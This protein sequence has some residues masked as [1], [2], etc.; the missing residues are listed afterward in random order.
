MP[1]GSTPLKERLL[2]GT[3]PFHSHEKRQKVD[4]DASSSVPRCASEFGG[5][6]RVPP[7]ELTVNR[8]IY[9]VWCPS[10]TSFFPFSRV[11]LKTLLWDVSVSFQPGELVALMGASGAGKT[12]LL[13]VV[14]GEAGGMVSSREG[15]AVS[16]NLPPPCLSAVSANS[17]PLYRISEKE[18][19]RGGGGG[20]SAARFLGERSRLGSTRE[21]MKRAS[22][23]VPQDDTL[24]S[25]LTARQTLLYAAELSMP[26]ASKSERATRVSDVLSLLNLTAAAETKVGKS[27]EPNMRGLSGGERKRL[28]IGIELL[29][30]PSVLILDE[31][32]TGLDSRN[33]EDVLACLRMLA[34]EGR[35]VICSIHQPS[36][37]MMSRFDRV[38]LLDRGEVAY[39][40]KVSLLEKYF[41][42]LGVFV[43]ERENPIERYVRAIQDG[44]G[45]EGREG[46][47][48]EKENDGSEKSRRDQKRRAVDFPSEW[49]RKAVSFLRAND[50]TDHSLRLAERRLQRASDALHHPSSCP[51]PGMI[52]LDSS[53]APKTAEASLLAPSLA[54]ASADNRGFVSVCG[55]VNSDIPSESG[56]G[57]MSDSQSGR[58]RHPEGFFEGSSSL[59]LPQGG[60]EREGGTEWTGSVLRERTEVKKAKGR[61]KNKC[62]PSCFWFRQVSILSRRAFRDEFCDPKKFLGNCLT[63]LTLGVLVGLCW[64]NQGRPTKNS[65]IFPL[66]GVLFMIVNNSVVSNLIGTVLEFPLQRALLIRE[67]RN[68]MFA[69]S[70]YFCATIVV[71]LCTN[72]LLSL[73]MGLP[74][75]F[76]VGLHEG[77]RRL[78]VFICTLV[79]Q[80]FIGSSL[81]LAVGALSNDFKDAQAVVVPILVPLMLFSGYVLPFDSIPSY[82]KWVYFCSFFQYALSLLRMNQFK[83]VVF[84][85]CDPETHWS[86][87][88]GICFRT[89]EEYLK[90][91][92]V[93][94]DP[95]TTSEAAL[96]AVLLAFLFGIWAVGF[97]L[98]KWKLSRRSG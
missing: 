47:C 58:L 72:L 1:Q 26:E 6:C 75:Y 69:L 44:E 4:R 62:C 14:S 3:P 2:D 98:L 82:M 91:D 49:R 84:E 79:I 61:R 64:L 43:G 60:I 37:S 74:V 73:L 20:T 70:A 39:C 89:G 88:T 97:A 13:K 66:S 50:P 52:S 46:E 18:G 67:Y 23:I 57:R 92:G 45:E 24:L 55:G 7:V 85:E 17:R 8:L 63:K 80:S 77:S 93:N 87:E 65:S 11:R 29:T 41:N 22:K 42:S 34:R 95:Q 25:T 21:W 10:P 96:L 28:S 53:A 40:G 83:G 19:R 38:V 90:S 16:S 31:P 81:G 36:F 54:V 27:Q 56:R 12:T 71:S 35:T 48:L 32:T 59:F 33:A 78:C 5:K 86:E 76:F 94:L 15:S 30:D 9:N 51:S 68:G